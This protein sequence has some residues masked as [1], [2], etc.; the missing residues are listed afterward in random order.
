MPHPGT[1]IKDTPM[2]D[3]ATTS[4]LEGYQLPEGVRGLGAAELSFLIAR[5]DTPSMRRSAELLMLDPAR[6]EQAALLAGASSLA[7]RGWLRLREEGEPAQTLADAALIEYLT[8]NATRWTRLGFV[9]EGGQ[10]AD[11]VLFLQSDAVSGLFQ[12][13]ELAAWFVK[14]GDPD[15]DG[16][17]L[18]TG[19]IRERLDADPASGAFVQ[20]LTLDSSTN[21]AVRRSG[22]DYEALRDVAGKG[23]GDGGVLDAAGLAAAIAGL[24]AQEASA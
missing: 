1:E 5:H 10:E 22:A 9:G 14:L 20:V 21:L 18:V 3:Q 13:R 11:Y 16:P 6:A 4:P 12:P 15:L 7:S 2:T 17:Q 8:G 23:T 24:Y 19:L